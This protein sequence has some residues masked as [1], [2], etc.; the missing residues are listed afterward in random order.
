MGGAHKEKPIGSLALFQ[1]R[2]AARC[3]FVS[4]MLT[5]SNKGPDSEKGGNRSYV[6][7]G[8]SEGL[9]EETRESTHCV[10]ASLSQYLYYTHGLFPLMPTDLNGKP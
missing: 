8:S 2:R 3:S 10:H 1:V 4:D 5:Q 7:H 9:S 6:K